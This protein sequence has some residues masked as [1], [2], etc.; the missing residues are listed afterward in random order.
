MTLCMMYIMYVDCS[1]VCL[2][3]VVIDLL[4]EH[5][6]LVHISEHSTENG[7]PLFTNRG[8][9]ILLEVKSTVCM[10]VEAHCDTL[11]DILL[12]YICHLR[13]FVC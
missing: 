11:H 13:L 2:Y 12:C 8:N 4:D 9:Y 1:F 10:I 7:T 6:D 3:V 5:G